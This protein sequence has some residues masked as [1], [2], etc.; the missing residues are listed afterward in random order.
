MNNKQ[1]KVV[2]R[3]ISVVFYCVFS[4]LIILYGISLGIVSC[5]EYLVEHLLNPFYNKV[6]RLVR[7]PIPN[8]TVHV[9][10]E[11]DNYFKRINEKLL[12]V[13]EAKSLGKQ[14]EDKGYEVSLHLSEF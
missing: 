6:C 8:S 14:Y 1:K 10:G 5:M 9:K 7:G 3:I 4:P 2:D 11:E 13:K 12:T